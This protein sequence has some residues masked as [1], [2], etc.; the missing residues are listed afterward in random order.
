MYGGAWW[1]TVHRVAQSWTQL[2]ELS[3]Q[4]HFLLPSNTLHFDLTFHAN[5]F[6][7]L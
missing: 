6:A 4:A 5:P 2:K 1:V 7:F 3:T